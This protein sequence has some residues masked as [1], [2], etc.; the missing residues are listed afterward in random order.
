M[1][2]KTISLTV[3]AYERLRSAR[4]SANESF[5]DVVLRAQWPERGMTGGELLS[6]IA[7]EPVRFSETELDALDR[8]LADDRPP[9]DPWQ[10]P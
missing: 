5:T 6:W 8:V 4:R 10:R 7:S 9:E 1:A 3:E 2:T